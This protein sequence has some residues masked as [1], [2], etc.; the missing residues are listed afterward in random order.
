MVVMNQKNSILMHLHRQ[1]ASVIE[2]EQKKEQI[3]TIFNLEK[4]EYLH[5]EMVPFIYLIKQNIC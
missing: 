2:S 3:F 5:T 4:I 1:R